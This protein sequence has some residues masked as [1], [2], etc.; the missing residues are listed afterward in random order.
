MMKTFVYNIKSKV[1]FSRHLLELDFIAENSEFLSFLIIEYLPGIWNSLVNILVYLIID[2]VGMYLKFSEYVANQI[3]QIRLSMIHLTMNILIL[4]MLSISA[5]ADILGVGR[6]LFT[7]E[8]FNQSVVQSEGASFYITI[9]LQAASLG[10]LNVIVRIT[11][12][13]N[14]CGS[15]K[16]VDKF[17]YNTRT[18]PLKKKEIDIWMYGYYFAYTATIIN[19]T[20]I[21]GLY[22]PILYPLCILYLFMKVLADGIMIICVFG[23]DMASNG[24][25]FA[26]ALRCVMLG[27][28]LLHLSLMNDSYWTENQLFFFIN[29]GM[30]IIIA[31]VNIMMRNTMPSRLS[32][33]TSVLKYV[34]FSRP[35]CVDKSDWIY[36]FCH[37]LIKKLPHFPYVIMELNPETDPG[38]INTQ[39]NVQDRADKL[40][41]LETLDLA[42]ILK[43]EEE[44]RLLQR[45]QSVIEKQLLPYRNR[46]L[47]HVV[48][49]RMDQD[50]SLQDIDD[51]EDLEQ[52]MK[53]MDFVLKKHKPNSP[54]IVSR[55]GYAQ[56]PGTFGLSHEKTLNPHNRRKKVDP[57]KDVYPSDIKPLKSNQSIEVTP[58]VPSRISSNQ[59]GATELQVIPE[60]AEELLNPQHNQMEDDHLPRRSPGNQSRKIVSS[61]PNGVSLRSPPSEGDRPHK[62][63]ETLSVHPSLTHQ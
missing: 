27:P 54:S 34:P 39:K 5:N 38:P 42:N 21:Y 12:L 23:N 16:K 32:R 50:K 37:P 59:R 14:N 19:A 53:D 52:D 41:K 55:K 18:K 47:E 25:M 48:L 7:F 29:I 24:T 28:F 45:S 6:K 20:S 60:G 44:P 36:K 49:Q 9:F 51:P 57:T 22:V 35:N 61:S 17:Y 62:L 63:L 58:V 11:D 4:P 3:Y 43:V 8:R 56:K 40:G 46:E 33:V 2:Q 13:F 10:F 30:M 26:S 31:T 15:C 1:P